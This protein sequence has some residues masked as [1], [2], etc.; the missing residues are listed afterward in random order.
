MVDFTQM[1]SWARD[2]F[3]LVEGEGARVRGVDGT[4]YLDAISGAFVTALGHGNQRVIDAVAKQLNRLSFNTPL[5]SSNEPAIALARRLLELAPEGFAAVK[6]IVTGAEATENAMKFAR[7]YHLHRN[8]GQRYKI[9]SHYRSYHGSTGH[10]LAAGGVPQFR[11]PYEPLA[12]GFVHIHPPFVLRSRLGIA[13]PAKLADAAL[14]LV[15]EA[16]AMEGPS[17]I[18]AMLV[19]PVMAAAGVRIYPPDY[20]RGLRA[21]TARHGIL[22]IFD[23][24]IT[25]FGRTGAWFAATREQVTPDILCF[26][27]QITSGYVPL[28]GVLLQEHVARTFWG[29]PGENRQYM[30]GTTFG[31]NPV[32]SAAGLATLAEMEERDLPAHSAKMGVRLLTSLQ[33]LVENHS[34]A[35]DARGVGLLGAVDFAMPGA[36]SVPAGYRIGTAVHRAAKRRGLLVRDGADYVILSPPLIVEAADIDEIERILGESIA[37]V[38]AELEQPALAAVGA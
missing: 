26:A 14:S 18:A 10:A 17:T 3:V 31:G 9:L 19:E 34:L 23:E 1:K 38:A 7:Q 13:D 11:I 20:L 25:G 21:I 24:V 36:R 28:S 30:G 8:E 5:Y 2:P 22:L 32:A 33:R 35:T 37:E 16:I 15:E 6:F 29:E 27:K 4:W 12:A